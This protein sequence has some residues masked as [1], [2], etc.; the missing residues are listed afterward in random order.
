MKIEVDNYYF[1]PSHLPSCEDI[2]TPAG[3]LEI[4]SPPISFTCLRREL[5]EL[6]LWTPMVGPRVG[7]MSPFPETVGFGEEGL[8]P[9]T[10]TLENK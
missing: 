1:L 7:P 4:S 2:S 8:G 5:H 9:E 10:L 3:S 6:S